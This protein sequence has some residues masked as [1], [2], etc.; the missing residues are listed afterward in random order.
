MIDLTDKKLL[1][2]KFAEDF[3][4]PLHPILAD[5]YLL[6]GDLARAKRVCEVGLDHDSTNVD[7]KFIL[8]KVAIAE[9]KLTLAEK[10]FKQVVNENPAHFTALRLLINIEIKLKRSVKTIQAYIRHLLQFIPYD[11]ECLKWLNEINASGNLVD[12]KTLPDSAAQKTTEPVVDKSYEVVES[13][14]TFTMVGV[15]KSQKHFHQALAVLEILKSKGRNSERISGEEAEI[16]LLIKE[17][18]K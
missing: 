4:T 14:A 3:A 7:S 17:S 2:T 11:D 9:N 13:M 8:G 18:A 6:E 15:L 5:M 10:W 12:S 1:E 16:Q